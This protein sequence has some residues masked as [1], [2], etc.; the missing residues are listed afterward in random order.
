MKTLDHIRTVIK[1]KIAFRD[2]LS[3][4]LMQKEGYPYVRVDNVIF[5]NQFLH[6]GFTDGDNFNTCIITE[7][8]V[9]KIYEGR[10]TRMV[11]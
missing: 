3:K 5:Y 7:H 1:I 9:N 11:G 4:Y 6:V 8:D 10:K 2:K